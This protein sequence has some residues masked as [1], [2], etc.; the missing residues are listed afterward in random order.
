MTL[1]PP[2]R[3]LGA[4]E[5]G[6][7]PAP[8]A[9]P[10]VVGCVDGSTD[11]NTR[12]FEVL[13]DDDQALEL[14]ELVVT[15]QQMPDGR[16]A[17]VHYGIVVEQRAAIEG[18]ETPSDTRLIAVEGTMP[19]Q[20]VRRAE[21]QVLRTVP[22]RWLAPEPGAAV[23]RATGRHREEALFVDQMEG[24][25]LPLGLDQG[26]RPVPA[27]FA[28]LNGEQGG[29][30]TIS[31]ISG[32]A[33][34]TSYALFALYM[35]LESRRGRELMGA[36]AANARA[37]AFNVKGEDLL[38]LD[39][40]NRR[41]RDEHRESWRR[42]GVEDPRPFG[43]VGFYVPP[44]PGASGQIVPAAATRAAAD[45]HVYGWTP[46]VFIRSGLLRFCLPDDENNQ[47][48]FVEQ[49]VRS[50]LA[51]H[52]YPLAGEE[53]S[54]AVV[55]CDEPHTASRTFERVVGS[56]P[57]EPRAAGE[58]MVV[59]DFQD[60]VDLL[61]RRLEAADDGGP[62]DWSGRTAPGTVMAFLRRIMALGPRLG[63]LVRTGVREVRLDD[64]LT[65]VDI[66]ALHES[67]Q[68]FVVGALVSRLFEEKQATGREPLRYVLLDELNKYAPREGR[69]PLRELFVDIAERGRSLGVLLIGCQQ[70]AGRVAEPCVRQPAM[71][72]C[73]RLDATEAADYR[74]LSPELRERATRF[75]PGTMVFDQPL[76][77]APIPIRF[78]YPPYATNV[79][80]A[81]AGARERDEARAAFDAL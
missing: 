33:A 12:R 78:P 9:G 79:S 58:G 62:A 11:A 71:K 7:A 38:H 6:G 14:D 20:T 43:D 77:P 70:A 63:H 47:V 51:R 40:A 44:Q 41:F 76:V 27:D 42:L 73:G 8:E 55:V 60:L 46:W 13:L 19:G 10:G 31:G 22:E 23:R 49:V 3:P 4:T 39:R 69:G 56:R 16:G 45:L 32:V 68:R 34:K 54:G 15:E 50:Q 57:P 80:D 65:V 74:F 25:G 17:V 35:L 24:R 29:H 53:S 36:Q 81:E 72:V 64:S 1:A 2:V 26:G 59:R 66:H 75:L 48:G 21:V 28:Y 61:I 18:A 37:L 67:A 30:F 5:A 52:A